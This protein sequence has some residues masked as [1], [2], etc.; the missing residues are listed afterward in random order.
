MNEQDRAIFKSATS[1][2]EERIANS[3]TPFLCQKG[4]T[5]DTCLQRSSNICLRIFR[6][7]SYFVVKKT[8][9]LIN[10]YL[11]AKIFEK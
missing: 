10:Y 1:K 5:G 6:F 7:Y 2:K 4:Y 11:F 3:L 8:E 9:F